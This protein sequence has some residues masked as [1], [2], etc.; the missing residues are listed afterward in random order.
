MSKIFRVID[1]GVEHG[2]LNIAFDQALIDARASGEIPDTIR[3]LRFKPTALVGRHQALSR[4][5]DVDYCAA[6]GIGL[7]RRITGGGSIFFDE[8]QLGWELVFHRASLPAPDLGATAELI[9]TA[10]AEGLRTL[11]IDARFRPRNDIEVDGRKISGTGGFFDGDVLFYQG[12]LLIDT[13]PEVMAQALKVPQAKL[14]KRDLDSAAQRVVTLRALL[15]DR[16]PGIDAAKQALLQGFEAGLG[17]RAEDGEVS[18]REWARAREI[19]DEEIGTDDFVAEIDDPESDS[20]FQS[21]SITTPGG[22]VTVYLRLHR[23]QQRIQQVLIT[24]D[25]FANP[26]RLVFDLEAALKDAPLENIGDTID[27][28]LADGGAITVPGDALAGVI[29]EAAAGGVS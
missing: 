19:H 8:G 2:R 15:G 20:G 24:G 10:A 11:G 29:R 26:P 4:E 3:F 18:E 16:T 21:A 17:L 22:S 25:F 7:G 12:T 14:A 23:G 6:N 13:N 9:C 28:V 1:T 27:A 5:V